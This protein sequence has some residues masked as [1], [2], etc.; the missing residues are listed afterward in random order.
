[1]WLNFTKELSFDFS[2][3]KF[4]FG[5]TVDF[6]DNDSACFDG[7]FDGHIKIFKNGDAWT[8]A[9]SPPGDLGFYG[10]EL[11]KYVTGDGDIYKGTDFVIKSITPQIPYFVP[12]GGDNVI[13]ICEP[14]PLANS[15][16]TSF[17]II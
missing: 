3:K 5:T 9:S 14:S 6:K 12:N 15:E 7:K 11:G 10:D 13:S 8:N 1:M 4:N 17:G 16:E 2:Y